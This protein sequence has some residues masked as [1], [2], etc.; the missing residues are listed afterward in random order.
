MYRLG[1]YFYEII[2]HYRLC[3]AK[4]RS[5]SIFYLICKPYIFNIVTE[6]KVN[7]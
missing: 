2:S 5:V 3:G 6:I 1:S 7:I 4:T